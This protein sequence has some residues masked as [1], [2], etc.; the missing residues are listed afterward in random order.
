MNKSMKHRLAIKTASIPAIAGLAAV[1]SINNAEAQVVIGN[2]YVNGNNRLEFDVTGGSGTNWLVDCKTTLSSSYWYNCG[3]IHFTNGAAH[4]AST[5]T[6]Y[7]NGSPYFFQVRNSSN[8]VYSAN[9]YGAVWKNYSGGS[10]TNFAIANQFDRGNTL[11]TVIPTAQSGT[12]I[13]K[14]D[15]GSQSWMTSTYRNGQW[16]SDFSCNPGEGLLLKLGSSTNSLD[17]KYY[18]TLKEGTL[19]TSVPSAYGFVAS[20]TYA[21]GTAA[22]LGYPAVYG[23]R[24]YKWGNGDWVPYTYYGTNWSSYFTISTGE[25]FMTYKNAG[26]NWSVSVT[27]P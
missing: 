18:G 1:L 27:I 21:S 10:S 24:I 20:Q 25:S 8:T 5:N 22:D 23:D 12:V 13:Y 11:N 6:L 17:V 26:T 4:F 7:A 16:S 19:T 2:G 9:V 14:W 3:I 15:S